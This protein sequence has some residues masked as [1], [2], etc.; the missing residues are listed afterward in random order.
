MQPPD[1][2]IIHYE[3]PDFELIP[4]RDVNELEQT[5]YGDYRLSPT[6]ICHKALHC[7][8]IRGE[9][10]WK[11][12]K[13]IK[14]N[15]TIPVPKL[16]GSYTVGPITPPNPFTYFG[17][18]FKEYVTYTFLEDIEGD[19]VVDI[20]KD[21]D[22]DTK[23]VLSKEVIGFAKQLH[24]LGEGSY[25]GSLERGPV[26]ARVFFESTAHQGTDETPHR[27]FMILRS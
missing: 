10:L 5:P 26:G 6:V 9:I 8:P 22:E 1:R 16:Y 21:M 13:F 19:R 20:W 17:R 2:T 3:D 4:P 18:G 11:T 25:V 7:R 23:L 15:T 27:L 12:L 14:E 24:D